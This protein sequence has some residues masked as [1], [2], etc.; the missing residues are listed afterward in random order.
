MK[1]EGLLSFPVAFQ[2]NAWSGI[3]RHIS[4][5][6]SLEMIRNGS[7]KH[8]V[9]RLRGYLDTGNRAIYDREKKRLPAVTFSADFDARRNRQSVSNYNR[10]CVIDIDK[11]ES[12]QMEQL[13]L[14][15]SADPYIF[16]F[17][18]SPSKVGIKGLVYFEFPENGLDADA[19]FRHTYGFMK[20]HAYILAKY[21][22]E[23]DTSGSD[24]T[25]LCFFS[26]DPSLHIQSDFSA[27]SITYSA[28][29]IIKVRE[30]LKS[31]VHSY[32]AEA[33]LNQKFNPAGKNNQLNRSTIQAII[34][35]LSK[36][37]LSITSS[38][39]NWYEIGYALSNTFTYELALK[40]YLALSKLDGKT[41]N[42]KGCRN[43]LEYCFANSMGKFSFATIVH[44]A[45]QV[46]YGGERGVPKVAEES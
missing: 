27:F 28:A 19:N 46:G 11:L 34:R 23:I 7:Y 21:G 40:Y 33:T 15:F 10:L 12:T 36:R 45:Q 38:F 35:F 29:D 22:V 9:E 1:L 3:S 6:Q 41:F 8:S 43:M 24:V 37:D 44:Y 25:R 32:A 18:E 39:R 2:E 26:Y 20:V 13:K 42:E 4:V 31:P 16:A 14:Q 17:W 5:Q 30:S